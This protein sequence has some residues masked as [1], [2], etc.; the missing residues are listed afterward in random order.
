MSHPLLCTHLVYTSCPLHLHFYS[1]LTNGVISTIFSLGYNINIRYLFFSFW[2]TSQ[3]M[4]DSRSILLIV[5]S[6]KNSRRAGLTSPSPPTSVQAG[7]LIPWRTQVSLWTQPSHFSKEL[8]TGLFSPQVSGF[9]KMNQVLLNI[10][11]FQ[12]SPPSPSWVVHSLKKNR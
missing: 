11:T 2:L 9:L 1:Y 10:K 6:G 8:I 5:L 3:C 4:T 12:F 7:E